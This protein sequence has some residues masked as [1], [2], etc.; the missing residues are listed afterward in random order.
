MNS[1]RFRRR[2]KNETVEKTMGWA[3]RGVCN[4][5][6][7]SEKKDTPRK[8]YFK[9]SSENRQ[10]NKPTAI[11]L[12]MAVVKMESNIEKAKKREYNPVFRLGK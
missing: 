7:S 9:K 6:K 11:G 10:F 5:K 1:M 12:N 4:F 8:S 3:E 2:F